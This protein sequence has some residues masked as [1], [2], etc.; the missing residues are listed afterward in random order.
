M[1]CDSYYKCCFNIIQFVQPMFV[2]VYSLAILIITIYYHSFGQMMSSLPGNVRQK[3]AHFAADE[4]R[5]GPRGGDAGPQSGGL[6]I[7]MGSTAGWYLMTSRIIIYLCNVCNVC[8]IVRYIIYIYVYCIYI[9][10]CKYIYIYIYI[11]TYPKQKGMRPSSWHIIWE[12][13]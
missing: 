10:V 8:I 4:Q 12:K 13:R 7:S 11:Y 3:S 9:Y 6:Q 5:P 1:I 2:P